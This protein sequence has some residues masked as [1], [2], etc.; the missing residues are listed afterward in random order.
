MIFLPGLDHR[1]A[2]YASRRIG[3]ATVWQSTSVDVHEGS[4]FD[5]ERSSEVGRALMDPSEIR[6]MV[7]YKQAV[8]II[9]NAPPVRLAYPPLAKLKDPPLPAREKIML[10]AAGSFPITATQAD[11]GGEAGREELIQ[12]MTRRLKP[13]E[14]VMRND[15]VRRDEGRPNELAQVAE[16]GLGGRTRQ[17]FGVLPLAEA[18]SAMVSGDQVKFEPEY[19]AEE[20]SEDRNPLFDDVR[21]R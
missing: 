12:A 11:S 21:E 14:K 9:G 8:A 6:R 18:N 17:V 13:D 15:Q 1:T 7:K 3:Q 4:K 2:E 16:V 10:S 5:S 20:I 19:D